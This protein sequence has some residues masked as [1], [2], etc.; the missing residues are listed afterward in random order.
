M[1]KLKKTDEDQFAILRK[2]G[3]NSKISQREMA[4][5]LGFSLGKLNYCLRAL[6]N[7]GLVKIKNFSNNPKKLNYLYILT[8][9]GIASKTKLTINFMKR[10]MQE[11]DKLK[12][13]L[14]IKQKNKSK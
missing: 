2:I 13:E 8:P 5:D 3:E 12:S 1:N 4:E 9:K 11:Y 10:K 14:N 7:K 6:Q